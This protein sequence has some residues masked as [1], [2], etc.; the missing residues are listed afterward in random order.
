MQKV[1]RVCHEFAEHLCGQRAAGDA[2]HRP[3]IVISHPDAG[4]EMRGKADKPCVAVAACRAGFRRDFVI[5][6]VRAAPRAFRIAHDRPQHSGHLPDMFRG[7][8][9]LAAFVAPP[10]A[11]IAAVRADAD[12]AVGRDRNA[13]VY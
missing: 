2:V 12:D 6:D 13:V 7:N 8:D 10:V 11:D 3:V 9:A 4:A 1:M 5:A